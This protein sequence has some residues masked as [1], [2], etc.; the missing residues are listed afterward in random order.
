[1]NDDAASDIDINR[2]VLESAD[3]CFLIDAEDVSK[4]KCPMQVL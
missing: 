2:N 4:S 3:Q 1:M